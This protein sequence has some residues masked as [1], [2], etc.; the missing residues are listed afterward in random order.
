MAIVAHH[1]LTI[2]QVIQKPPGG[3][4]GWIGRTARLWRSR[5]R[6]RR[7][8]EV[9]DDRALHDLAVSRWDFEREIAKPFWRG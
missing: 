3:F 1:P 6:E 4:A 9:I 7:S 5:I 8:F 2:F